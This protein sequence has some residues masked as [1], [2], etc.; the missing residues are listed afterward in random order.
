MGLA[1]KDT[2][3][4]GLVFGGVSSLGL[5]HRSPSPLFEQGLGYTGAPSRAF[6]SKTRPCENK[7]LPYFPSDS[8]GQAR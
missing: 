5:P 3:T 2:V 6:V 1:R 7:N 4:E 8:D